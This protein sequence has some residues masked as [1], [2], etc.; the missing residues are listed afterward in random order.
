MPRLVPVFMESSWGE[1]MGDE[2]TLGDHEARIKNVEDTLKEMRADV[3]QILGHVA[4]SKGGWKVVSGLGSISGVLA[5]L[6][7]EWFTRRG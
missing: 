4:A 2:R 3:K 6:V 1:E 5:A 7:T